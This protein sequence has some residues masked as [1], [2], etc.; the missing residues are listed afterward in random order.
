MR[1][2]IARL[3]N[4]CEKRNSV[5]RRRGISSSKESNQEFPV[6]DERWHATECKPEETLYENGKT[7]PNGAGGPFCWMNWLPGK[8][9]TPDSVEQKEKLL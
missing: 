3:R 2:T 4:C 5:E 7:G 8:S 6:R 1:R 9:S